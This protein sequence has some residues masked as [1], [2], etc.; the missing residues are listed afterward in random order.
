[1]FTTLAHAFSPI[2]ADGTYIYWG[3]GSSHMAQLDPK[4]M[5][6]IL[7]DSYRANIRRFECRDDRL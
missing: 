6:D 3:G 4:T 5:I 7:P 1:M 2:L